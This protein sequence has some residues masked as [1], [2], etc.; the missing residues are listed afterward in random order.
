MD[1]LVQV[2]SQFSIHI[3]SCYFSLLFQTHTS[4]YIHTSSWFKIVRVRPTK[5]VH[6]C[7][8]AGEPNQLTASTFNR[9]GQNAD[10]T[11][12]SLSLTHSLFK[13]GDCSVRTLDQ[14]TVPGFAV[15]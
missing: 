13:S 2:R 9:L 10:I 11:I 7:T 4:M 12:A 5:L 15:L 8:S 3:S 1:I 6:D 14:E